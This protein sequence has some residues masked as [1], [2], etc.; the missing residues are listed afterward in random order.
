[1][2]E[3]RFPAYARLL[4]INTGT[5]L[6]PVWSP[7]GFIEKNSIKHSAEEDTRYENSDNGFG[8]T[9]VNGQISEIDISGVYVR[10]DD[11]A[12]WILAT[13]YDITKKNDNQVQIEDYDGSTI[14][15][16]KCTIIVEETGNDV[17]KTASISGKI[18]LGG[19]PT[20]S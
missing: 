7:I 11:A 15:Y 13:E 18:I 17:A 10:G 14:V 6:V 1:M 4:S 2:A 3:Q 8:V 16:N 5:V 20:I 19:E 12:E 9:R